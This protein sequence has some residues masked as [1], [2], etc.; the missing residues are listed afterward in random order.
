M[1]R[2]TQYIVSS[3]QNAVCRMQQHIENSMQ[4]AVSGI[5]QLAK[6]QPTANRI[7]HTA[8]CLL[9]F[10]QLTYA[11]LY[12]VQVNQTLIPP[13]NTKLNSYATSSNVKLRLYL[14]MTDVNISNRQV[15]LKLKIKGQGL[16]IQS[17]DFV[18]GAPIIYLNGGTQQQFTNIDLAPYFQLN[19]L[20]GINPQQYNRHLPE[21]TY[22]ICW[23]VYD[24]MTN[25]LISNPNFGCENIYLLL[26]DP[27][28]LNLPQRGD[29]LTETEPTNIIFQWTPRHA[30]ATNVSY[31]FELRELWDTQIDPQV[32]FLSSPNYY[33]ETTRATTLLYNI[34]KPALLPGY[35]YAWR[36]QAKSSTG[37]S[38]NSVFKND[39]YSEIFYFTYT[40]TCYPPTFVLAEP[41]NTGIVK[42]SWQTN[43][44]Q[45]KYHV[46]YK[47][48]DVDDA[49]WFEVFSYNNQAQITNLQEGVTYNFR[50]GGLC[51]ALTDLDQTYSYS[52]INQFTMPT[53]DETVSYSCGIVP[54]IEIT[55]TDPLSN[56][57]I[58]E[59]FT[60]GDFPVTVTEIKGGN[61]VFSGTGYISVPYLANAKIAVEFSGIKINTDY[62]LISGFVETKYDPNWKS[63][64]DIDQAI[65]DAMTLID[66]IKEL[67]NL[68]I[69]S[70][71]KENIEKLTNALVLQAQESLPEE[72]VKPYKQA[73][74]NLVSAK[75]K[76][77]KAKESGNKELIKEAKKEFKEAQEDLKDA[78][79]AKD[80]FIKEFASIIKDALKK[81]QR[82]SNDILNN[83]LSQ[84]GKEAIEEGVSQNLE[85]QNTELNELSSI[86]QVQS[87]SVSEDEQKNRFQYERWEVLKYISNSLQSDTGAENL[88][89]LLEREG[90]KLGIYVYE[91]LK[92][93]TNKKALIE[94]VKEIIITIVTEKI[95]L[96]T[97]LF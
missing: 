97:K 28:F 56:I 57:G 81:I 25:Q 74:E 54:D 11:Q 29:Q 67:L 15:R 38:E 5:E 46:Q 90:E 48:A 6:N 72:L 75:E 53:A 96:T 40:N 78:E 24:Y 71:T 77:D 2:I 12:P 95:A 41:L 59:T 80:K 82:E 58:N 49:E 33:T 86:L 89:N 65:D 60:A 21:G 92:D 37:L 93:E 32:G 52:S 20:L 36:V 85:L 51:N 13:Y 61:G 10:C 63:I 76:Y 79:I 39:G 7:L 31:E 14:T 35:T 44:D 87:L 9:L 62:Q 64:I 66:I 23:E 18:T 4:Y 91:K 19:N 47:R 17:A 68:N 83:G 69:D 16:N 43:P 94:E 27:P 42:I 84:Y 30:S 26:N 55:N 73:S 8:T 70:T 50:V 1:K 88:G 34:S 3:I 22:K 45:N